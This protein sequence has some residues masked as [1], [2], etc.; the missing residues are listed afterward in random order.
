MPSKKVNPPT[1]PSTPPPPP[2]GTKRSAPD[3]DDVPSAKRAR[4]AD[5]APSGVP[6]SPSKKRKLDEDGLILIDAADT[7]LDDEDIIVID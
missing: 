6:F 5:T 4:K 7:N 1:V 3:D 2:T